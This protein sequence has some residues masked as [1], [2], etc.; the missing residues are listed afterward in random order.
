MVP[1][2]LS[3][4][5]LSCFLC[6]LGCRGTPTP[7]CS[8]PQ[9]SPDPTA[10]Q[11]T[12]KADPPDASAHPSAAGERISPQSDRSPESDP[13]L[14]TEFRP[15]PLC[16]EQYLPGDVPK[17]QDPLACEQSGGDRTPMARLGSIFN[18]SIANIKT[19]YSNYYSLDCLLGFAAFLGPAAVTA[20]SDL[21]NEFRNWYQSHL[22]TP[23]TNQV[24]KACKNLGEA[25]YAVPVYAL[26]DL[27]GKYFEENPFMGVMGDFGDRTMR[28]YAVGAPPMLLMQEVL[29]S[30]RPSDTADNSYW[31]PFQHDNGVSGHMFVG[32]VPFITAANMSDNIPEKAFFYACSTLAGW[33]RIND[34]AHYLS[35]VWMGWGMAYLACQAV[36]KTQQENQHFTITPV[37]TP[38]MSGIGFIYQH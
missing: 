8:Q 35:E 38:Q 9:A 6:T 13:G 19:D 33:S 37:V 15:P 10:T 25:Q 32:A 5:L 29:G 14:P 1:R 23:T 16:G 4:F 18:T 31:R 3:L 22:V 36:N 11:T 30:G 2:L 28:A 26:M 17:S 7:Y 27:A 21:D 12:Q 20:N 24:A 34:D